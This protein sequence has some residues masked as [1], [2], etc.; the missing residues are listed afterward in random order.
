MQCTGIYKIWK[1][2]S[3]THPNPTQPGRGLTVILY[4]HQVKFHNSGTEALCKIHQSDFTA[5]S[6]PFEEKLTNIQIIFAL[7]WVLA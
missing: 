2:P 5:H 4:D 6:F 1:D 7:L 3:P